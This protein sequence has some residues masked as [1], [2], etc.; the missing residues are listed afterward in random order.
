MSIHIFHRLAQRI[1]EFFNVSFEM[2]LLQL[3]V[4]K[5]DKNRF[6]AD[7]VRD[8]IY[9]FWL[10]GTNKV[11]EYHHHHAW[12]FFN[13]KWRYLSQ[14]FVLIYYIWPYDVLYFIY[15]CAKNSVMSS[16]NYFI[17]KLRHSTG[18]QLHILH[19]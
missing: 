9:F 19:T 16:Y 12:H 17:F 5:S 2:V 11:Y 6:H 10:I 7:F 3:T 4:S 8:K 15:R 18:H 1:D 14:L 13:N